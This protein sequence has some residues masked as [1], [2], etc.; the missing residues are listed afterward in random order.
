VLSLTENTLKLSLPFRASEV[1][2][3]SEVILRIVKVYLYKMGNLT[4]LGQ[5]PNFTAG[6]TGNFTFATA[7][8]SHIVY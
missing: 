1:I 6:E 4:A 8:T 2:F 3:D 5:G 7:K